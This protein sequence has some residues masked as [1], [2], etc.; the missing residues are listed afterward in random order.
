MLAAWTSLI[1]LAVLTRRNLRLGRG[2]R[3]GARRLAIGMIVAGT[4]AVSLA[5]HSPLDLLVARLDL[6]AQPLMWGLIAWLAYLGFEPTIRRT[7]PH[8][9]ITSTRLL[10]LR[11]RDPLVGRAVLAGVL[12]GL[13]DALPGS[14]SIQRLLDLPGGGPTVFTQGPLDAF[15]VFVGLQVGQLALALVL[16]LLSL[17][18]LLVARLIVRRT[19]VAWVVFTLWYV[20]YSY[21]AARAI[22]PAT[23]NPLLLLAVV[24][25]FSLVM[26]WLLWKHGALAMVTAYVVSY[27]VQQAP[28]T[29]DMSRYY[30][31]RAWFVATVVVALAFWGFR[32]V[33]GRQS[34]FPAGTLD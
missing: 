32:N 25:V 14:V 29:L 30:A 34:A 19:S 22:R 23:L 12:V 26:L 27:L 7:W 10:D 20:A 31:W 4:L 11:L 2:D 6:L 24:A 33:L 18:V 15:R 28:W 3:T 9:L 21:L 17:A 16:T 1:V 5:E 8:L 13:F